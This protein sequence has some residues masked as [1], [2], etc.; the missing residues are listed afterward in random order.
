MGFFSNKVDL[1][2][3]LPAYPAV[4][5][6]SEGLAGLRLFIA[7]GGTVDGSSRNHLRVNINGGGV[8][9]LDNIEA[10]FIISGTDISSDF[11]VLKDGKV[12]A[13][14]ENVTDGSIVIRILK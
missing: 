10:C 12:V 5:I 4:E 11:F 3:E 6:P 2:L 8:I 14:G 7:Q 1:N 13:S 9:D